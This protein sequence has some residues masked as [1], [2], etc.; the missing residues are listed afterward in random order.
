MQFEATQTNTEI[1]SYVNRGYQFPET[2]KESITHEFVTIDDSFQHL[3]DK[4]RNIVDN[5]YFSID[6]F[7][8]K[9][10]RYKWIGR[11]SLEDKTEDLRKQFFLECL[12][13]SVYSYYGIKTP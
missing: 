6:R 8:E 10:T 1:V 5:K 3:Y 2:E 9:S 7:E 12:V 4:R 11:A 13:F